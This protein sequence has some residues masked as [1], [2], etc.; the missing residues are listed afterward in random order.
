[1]KNLKRFCHRFSGVNLP[2][3]RSLGDQRSKVSD[4]LNN[5]NHPFQI[6]SNSEIS[7]DLETNSYNI[8]LSLN[9]S[10]YLQTSQM[11][12]QMMTTSNNYIHT[13]SATMTKLS[14]PQF[15]SQPF[16]EADLLQNG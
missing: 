6:K 1:M 12:G 7:S 10:Q 5:L 9:T 15:N 13:S 11:Q 2:K 3:N 4:D 16:L 14:Q 8:E